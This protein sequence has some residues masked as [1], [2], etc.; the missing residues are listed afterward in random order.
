MLENILFA[1]FLPKKLSVVFD[2]FLVNVGFNS[3]YLETTKLACY[4][5]MANSGRHAV[6]GRR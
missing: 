5:F 4:Y 1:L 2:V 6:L 3:T